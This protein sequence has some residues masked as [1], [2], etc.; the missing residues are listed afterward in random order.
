MT[1]DDFEVEKTDTVKD[2]E[3]DSS[4]GLMPISGITNANGSA[5]VAAK[6]HITKKDSSKKGGGKNNK[7]ED[8]ESH[9]LEDGT[10]SALR[11]PLK[12]YRPKQLGLE[13]EDDSKA[14]A[15]L[16]W[17]RKTKSENI[18]MNDDENDNSNE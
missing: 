9:M 10:I 6:K 15:K 3:N 8:Q 14:R 17:Q 7:E 13:T 16:R 5:A 1:P 4:D 2:K 18:T 11:I 12:R